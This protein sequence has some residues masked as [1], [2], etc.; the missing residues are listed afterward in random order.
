[1]QVGMILALSPE[2][3]LL[4]VFILL[5]GLDLLIM[6]NVE[7]VKS[8]SKQSSSSTWKYSRRHRFYEEGHQDVHLH[9]LPPPLF[10]HTQLL[11]VWQV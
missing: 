8:T 11:T 1:M 3:A 5:D 10:W 7:F 2:E 6:E 9:D 4:S